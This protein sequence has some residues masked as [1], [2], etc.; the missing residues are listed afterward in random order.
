MSKNLQTKLL[1]ITENYESI[2][3]QLS[4]TEITTE[5]RIEL[6]KK[7]SWL[8]Q[9]IIKKNEVD[10]LENNLIQ[11][12]ETIAQLKAQHEATRKSLNSQSTSASRASSGLA[13]S[14]TS[15]SQQA[16]LVDQ[17]SAAGEQKS[18]V[19]LA[20]PKNDDKVRSPEAPVLLTSPPRGGEAGGGGS[21]AAKIDEAG[22]GGTVATT[23]SAEASSAAQSDEA[24]NGEQDASGDAAN[25]DEIAEA[26]F[27][28]SGIDETSESEH[29][30][31]E[32]N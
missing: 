6:S 14:A 25:D 27:N 32:G 4:S 8:E 10:Q 24:D 9:V 22:G 3:K 20:S 18:D 21:V 2:Q 13:M 17:T 30:D 29:S 12:Q 23:D 26:L 19:R 16:S 28:V 5:K 31:G 15:A 7:F 11:T 1:K